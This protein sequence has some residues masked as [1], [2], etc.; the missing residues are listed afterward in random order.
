MAVRVPPYYSTFIIG[1][2]LMMFATK[3][4]KS[5]HL[6]TLKRLLIHSKTTEVQPFF[7]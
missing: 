6:R 1:N 2:I 3:Q 4:Q 7:L 5:R